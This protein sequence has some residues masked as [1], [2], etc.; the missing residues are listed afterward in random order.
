[1]TSTWSWPRATILAGPFLSTDPQGALVSP[2]AP[3]FSTATST[4]SPQV[5]LGPI[6][7]LVCVPRGTPVRREN[8]GQA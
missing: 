2:P 6:P 5:S 1:V 7:P 8:G 3:P 4:A